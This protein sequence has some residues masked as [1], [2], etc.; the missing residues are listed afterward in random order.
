MTSGLDFGSRA[1]GREYPCSPLVPPR[2][3]RL[4]RIL[5]RLDRISFAWRTHSVTSSAVTSRVCG[6]L[7]PSALA[8]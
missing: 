3:L 5:H 8:V 7:R 4:H 1:G 2:P 6:T